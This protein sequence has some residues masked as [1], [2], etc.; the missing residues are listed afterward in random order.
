MRE[1]Q[2]SK[3]MVALVDDQDYEG[4]VKHTWCATL[5][6]TTTYAKSSVGRSYKEPRVYM[7]RYILGLTDGKTYV[8]HI[9]HNGLNN[10][11]S[12]LRVCTKAQNHANRKKKTGLTSKHVGVSWHKRGKKWMAMI[13]KDG[14]HHYLG[15]F[16][17][18]DAAG[19]AYDKAAK[20]YHGQFAT[21]NIINPIKNEAV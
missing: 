8:D 7:H 11:R 10:Q 21:T 3:G 2:L 4:L 1:I 14:R 19:E 6:G 17:S 12:N 9:D 5:N 18:E 13:V 15:L 16:T 20:L